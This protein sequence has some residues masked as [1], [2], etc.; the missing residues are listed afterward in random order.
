[1][2]VDI[3]SE[4][5]ASLEVISRALRDAVQA[6]LEEENRVRRRGPPIELVVD[7]IGNRPSGE[8]DPGLP[9]IQRAMAATRYVGAEP[10]LSRS[11]TNSN[12]PIALGIPAVTL[13]RGGEGAANHSPD[14]WWIN[15]DGY[16]AIQRALLLVVAEAGL[17]HRE[18]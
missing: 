11:S 16:L 4:S 13:G 7:E 10:Q 8:L 12:V 3:R 17:G 1:M 15:R 2:E 5:P 14:E 9:L 6:A 18:R